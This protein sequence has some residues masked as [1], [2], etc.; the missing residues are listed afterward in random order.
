MS[1][2]SR[3]NIHKIDLKSKNFV[4]FFTK[5]GSGKKHLAAKKAFSF[6]AKTVHCI[7]FFEV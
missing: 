2:L 4:I 1:Y 5:L 6:R 7:I 3:H